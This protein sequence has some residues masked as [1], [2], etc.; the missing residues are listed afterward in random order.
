MDD[1]TFKITVAVLLLGI[2]L[3][4]PL[5]WFA[6]KLH[7]ED[8]VQRGESCCCCGHAEDCPKVQGLLDGEPQD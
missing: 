6:Y 4:F 2:V 1:K 8:L 5:S 3:L 7:N